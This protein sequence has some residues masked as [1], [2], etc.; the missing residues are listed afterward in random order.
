[1]VERAE[2]TSETVPVVV[3]ATS[4]GFN[5]KRNNEAPTAR[6]RRL[7]IERGEQ[8][9]PV[10]VVASVHFGLGRAVVCICGFRG[11]GTSDKAIAEA[12]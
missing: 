9:A 1:M 5:G 7:R 3:D 12:F 11:T 4:H 6:A 10:H 8:L 2:S